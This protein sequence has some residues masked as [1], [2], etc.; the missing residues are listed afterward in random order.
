MLKRIYRVIANPG[1]YF[2]KAITLISWQICIPFGHSV[3]S[4][5]VDLGSGETPRNPFQAT[6]IIGTD[7]HA[8]FRLDDQ[9]EFV[10]CDLTKSLPFK[11]NS[12]SSFSAYD[13]IEH[14]PRWER[15]NDEIK[16]PFISLMDEIFRCLKPGGIFLAATPA[17][18]SPVAFQDP[19][20]IN[21]ISTATVSYFVG[22]NPLAKSFGYG[23]GGNFRLICQTWIRH[24]AIFDCRNINKDF[25]TFSRFRKLLFLLTWSNI[26]SI[27]LILVKTFFRKPTH[28]LWVLRKPL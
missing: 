21:F 27:V 16:F 11:D 20:H 26:I 23:Y 17:F 12:I 7:F 3:D 24:N 9:I 18:P 22:K 8:S 5:H 1:N 4:I 15:V 10:K 14:I 6:R 25:S 19:T 2:D 28:L 13:V